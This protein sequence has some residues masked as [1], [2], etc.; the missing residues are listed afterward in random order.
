MKIIRSFLN[1]IIGF[2]L[3]SFNKNGV[4]LSEFP[5]LIINNKTF[6]QL[7]YSCKE[8]N[9]SLFEVGKIQGIFGVNYFKHK[10]NIFFPTEDLSFY[11]E[12]SESIGFGKISIISNNYSKV[13]IKQDT[14]PLSSE[15]T[16]FEGLISGALNALYESNFKFEKKEN[17]NLFYSKTKKKS[18]EIFETCNYN[19]K[20]ISHVKNP[21]INADLIKKFKKPLKL[22]NHEVKFLNETS[23]FTLLSIYILIIK[24]LYDNNKTI[25]DEFAKNISKDLINSKKKNKLNLETLLKSYGFGEFITKRISNSKFSITSIKNPIV[26][27]DK[28]IFTKSESSTYFLNKLF[29]KIYETELQSNVKI[30][31]NISKKRI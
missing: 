18:K 9:L 3:I 24:Y 27:L 31:S 2:K 14:K 19:F 17:N 12:Q 22:E 1:R 26:E 11:L 25:L 10:H 4:F 28:N 20:T 13:E 8:N 7:L 21:Q 30:E 29:Q 6:D 23:V 5:M 15:N 16:Y